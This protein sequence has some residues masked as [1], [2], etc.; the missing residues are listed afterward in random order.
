MNFRTFVSL[1]VVLLL[2][3]NT[4]FSVLGKSGNDPCEVGSKPKKVICPGQVSFD[5]DLGSPR[6]ALPDDE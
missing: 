3:I 5:C 2:V 4:A 1:A 6:Y